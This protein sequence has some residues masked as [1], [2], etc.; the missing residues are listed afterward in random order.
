M[1]K[2][3][4][5]QSLQ[6]LGIVGMNKRN[7]SFIGKH[8]KR[9]NYRLVDDKLLTK[10][11]ALE[12]GGI[13][14][15]ELFGVVE[16]LFQI[17]D[18]LEKIRGKYPDAEIIC[19]LGNMD[20]TREGSP[21]PGYVQQAANTFNDKVHTL[22]VPYKNSPGHPKIE[23]QKIIADRLTDLILKLENKEKSLTIKVSSAAKA[24][25]L[26][27][28]SVTVDSTRIFTDLFGWA[29]FHVDSGSHQV[30]I[31]LDRFKDQ[32]FPTV[33]SSDT[34]INIDLVQ[35]LADVLFEV[36]MDD[37]GLEN[38]SISLA[39][40]TE[41]TSRRGMVKFYD[42]KA[43]TGYVYLIEKES[44]LLVED[45][46]FLRAD[47]SVRL[48]YS[49]VDIENRHSKKKLHIYPNPTRE[50]LNVEGF[51]DVLYFEILDVQ[52]K[53]L[54]EGNLAIDGSIN[55]SKLSAGIYFL[56]PIK[57]PPLKFAVCK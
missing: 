56:N 4:S 15:P 12:K 57:G 32:S 26:P 51:E 39:G 52:G 11:I 48:S 21:W 30:S 50:Q 37:W 36:K 22:F 31:R 40:E 20:I 5:P 2:L 45:S 6:S 19:L 9:S 14:V 1:I 41:I 27:N 35:D 34:L 7:I 16:Y 28:A 55:V 23:E 13:P 18:F 3:I 47:T 53:L 42:I 10:K 33:V 38:A 29:N 17:E 8:N 44:G 25:P 49:S 43:D 46:L 24:K 54:R